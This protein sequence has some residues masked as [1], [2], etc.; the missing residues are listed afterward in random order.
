MTDLL[1]FVQ[2]FQH[3][4]THFFPKRQILNYYKLKELADDNSKFDENG[5]K[6]SNRA[7]NT[8]GKG[9]V[10]RYQQFLFFQM[11]FQKTSTANT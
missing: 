3:Y 1:Y 11:C 9:E 5:G 2:Y 10:A 7:E 8:V 4:F 6:F